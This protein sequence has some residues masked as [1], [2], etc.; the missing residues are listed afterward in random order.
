MSKEQL[1]LF[2]IGPVQTFIKQARKTRDLYAGSQILS[3]LIEAGMSACDTYASG[4]DAS[5]MHIFPQLD[6]QDQVDKSLPNRFIVKLSFQDEPTEVQLKNLAGSA[7]G[8]VEYAVRSKFEDIAQTALEER[9]IS[10]PS[11]FWPQINQHLDIHWAF[12]PIEKEGYGSAYLAL[13]RQ[14]GAVKNIRRFN[15]LSWQ[16]GIELGER[17]RKCSL[18]GENN[19]LFYRKRI[20]PD[21]NQEELPAMLSLNELGKES[22]LTD[23]KLLDN[24]EWSDGEAL[25]AVST[26]KRLYKHDKESQKKY[27]STSEIALYKQIQCY[28]D[29]VERY[30]LTF[31]VENLLKLAQQYANFQMNSDQRKWVPWNDQFFYEENLNPK[32]IPNPKQL[33]LAREGLQELKKAGFKEEKYYALIHSDGDNM[34]KWLSGGNLAPETDLE[35]FHKQLSGL[36]SRFAST[37]TKIVDD[38]GKTVYAGGDDFLGFVNLHYLFKAIADLRQGFHEQVN[39]KLGG[40]ASE[41]HLTFSAGIVIAHYK[42]PLSMVLDKAREMEKE[43]KETGKRNA[44]G[45]AV[46]KASGEIQQTIFKWDEN[47]DSPDGYSNWEAM[48]VIFDYLREEKFSNTFIS[49]LTK[50]LYKLAGI[51]LKAIDQ[52][53][54]LDSLN[55]GLDCEIERLVSRSAAKGNFEK[56]IID[57]D[58]IEMVKHVRLLHN[59]ASD[60]TAHFIHAL[61]I[62]DFLHRKI[63]A[64]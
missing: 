46:V 21:T 26:V 18:D 54:A 15:Q 53:P 36:L 9:K 63:N 47:K 62:I 48:K 52:V 5:V 3:Q 39:N 29:Q 27:P 28:P 31:G 10:I 61:H 8:G 25:S 49:V 37:A 22:D 33:H 51:E 17:G 30:K 1:F 19:A 59:A 42:E 16:P 14:L 40:K 6:Q 2:T 64:N 4:M 44:F 56:N 34:G 35:T 23:N 57:K 38:F 50:E 55:R 32:N 60:N 11:G 24:A 58:I 45:L 7:E 43:A 13:E 41:K 20:N 12:Q